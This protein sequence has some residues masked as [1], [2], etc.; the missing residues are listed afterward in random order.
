MQSLLHVL[1]IHRPGPLLSLLCLA[2]TVEVAAQEDTTLSLP[3]EKR[4]SSEVVSLEQVLRQLEET[5]QI[6]FAYDGEVVQGQSLSQEQLDAWRA[7]SHDLAT[8]L[9]QLLTPFGLKHQKV[10]QTYI[11]QRSSSSPNEPSEHPQDSS[12]S[13]KMIGGRVT[14]LAT[15][16]GLP[17]VNIVIEGTTQGTVTNVEGH[18]QLTVAG[19]TEELVFSMVGYVREEVPIAD[20]AIIDLAMIPDIQSLD[21]V[22]VMGYDTQQK[23]D[24]TGAVSSIKFHEL[25]PL[26]VPSLDQALQGRAAG[27]YLNRTSG[28]PGAG[29]RLF[30]RGVSSIQGTD[31]LWIIDGMRTTPGPTFNMNDVASVEIL[32]DASAAAIYGSA[33][34]NGVVVVTTRRGEEGPPTLNLEA[35]AG[36]SSPLGLPTPL[37][38]QQYATLKNE[39]YDLGGNDRI[40]AYANPAALPPVST[41][42]LD[43]LYDPAPVQ[44]YHLSLSGG[45]ATT[46]YFISGGYFQEKGTYVGTSFERY[47]LRANSDIAVSDQLKVG[48]SLFLTYARQDPMNGSARDWIRATP[49]LP[50]FDSL[51]RF[52]GYGTVD[53]KAYQYEGGNPLANELRTHQLNQDYRVGGDLYATLTLAK[54]LSLKTN[55]GANV[56]VE[57]NRI[58]KDTYLGGGG[59]LRASTALSQQYQENVSILGNAIL[60]YDRQI[61]RHHFGGLLGYEAI[62]TNIEQYTASGANLSGGLQ[63]IDAADPASRNA[64]GQRFGDGILSQF[65]RLDY[66]YDDTYLLTI[67][68]RRD[69]SSRFGQ[70]ERYGIFPS[71]SVGWRLSNAAFMPSLPFLTDL[72]LR[73]SYGLLGNSLGLDRYLY[74]ASYA[75]GETLYTFG[76]AQKVV[77]G[78][79]PAR[80][81]NPA[82]KWEE[83]ETYDIGLDITL[84]SNRLTLTAD[85]YLKNTHDLLLTVGLPPSAGYLPHAWYETALNPVVNIGRIQN[86]GVEVAAGFRSKVGRH[87]LITLSANAAYNQNK[88]TRLNEDERILSGSWDGAGRVSVTE[89][90]QPLGSFYGL[91]VDGVIQDQEELNRLNEGAPDGVYVAEG[92]SPG[93][94]RYRDIGRFDKEGRFVADP[95][96]EI[97]DADQTFIGNPW[98][99]WVYGLTV[100]VTFKA[101]D[102]TCFFQ[103]VQGVDRFN[104]FKSLTHHLFADYSM[105][106]AAL[107]R[108]TAENPTNE[109]PRIIRGD[110]NRNRSRVSSYF[111]GDGSYL[112]LRTLQVGYT[113]PPELIGAST[114]RVYGSVQNLLTL[115]RYGGFD[116]EFD[117]TQDNTAKGIDRGPYPQ[118]RT[119]IVG[120]QLTF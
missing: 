74:E 27:V 88:V 64:D 104:S 1:S 33:A 40:P 98:P 80:L 17:G 82:I 61:N 42:W 51:N 53:R 22:V 112:R 107:Q 12:D 68:L 119:M 3:S 49:A 113:A 20:R 4:A 18:Y 114:L 81:A 8:L 110:P 105:T 41:D 106:T 60:S 63:V 92:T 30:I 94:F 77:P 54:G 52:G 10:H 116:P 47:S 24:V 120:L 45:S 108:W 100:N 99:R 72:K 109:H 90:G 29:A 83:V 19:D 11:I 93:D 78:I 91:I 6:N 97:T 13:K 101:F 62:R 43:V 67:N 25:P 34:A 35:S 95:D 16:E 102:L 79:R 84:F 86:R 66:H 115:T 37:N 73:A 70:D 103:G 15:E 9:N 48:E 58:F 111:V 87:G 56:I 44:N 7:T 5:N 46:S 36:V 57:N 89:V 2:V 71:A 50:V 28:A 117:T 21:E 96:G 26:A 85:Y 39:A 55:V 76:N 38:T 75:T 23:S 69:G 118:S 14:D 31:P 65:G 32:K 59:V